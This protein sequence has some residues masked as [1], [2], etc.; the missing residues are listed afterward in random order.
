MGRARNASS[1]DRFPFLR[2]SKRAEAGPRGTTIPGTGK[3]N[4]HR[5]RHKMAEYIRPR[6]GGRR[7]DKGRSSESHP[8]RDWD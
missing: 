7:R 5:R 2:A 1:G 6:V 8:R 3:Y 4:F